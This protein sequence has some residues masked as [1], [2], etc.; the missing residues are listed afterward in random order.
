MPANNANLHE[1]DS[2]VGSF[3]NENENKL[4]DSIVE[5]VSGWRRKSLRD[6]ALK[7]LRETTEDV[8]TALL[9]KFGRIELHLTDE[10]WGDGFPPYWHCTVTKRRGIPWVLSQGHGET[11]RGALILAL[12]DLEVP[13][14][15]ETSK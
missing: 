4:R 14:L 11:P 8:A 5:C 10:P 3:E 6:H 13:G 1:Y 12:T 7:H 15:W 2:V 9:L